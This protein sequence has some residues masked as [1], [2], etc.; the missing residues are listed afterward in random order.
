MFFD[1]LSD[2]ASVVDYDTVFTL[3]CV[4]LTEM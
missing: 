2:C 4:S 3:L 1:L